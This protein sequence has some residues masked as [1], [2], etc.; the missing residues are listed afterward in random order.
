[1]LDGQYLAKGLE[2]PMNNN[3]EV[4]DVLGIDISKAK[5]D[6]ALIQAIL[7]TNLQ[8]ERKKLFIG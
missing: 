5:F 1:L 6:V 4:N 2:A 8:N 3:N 7:W